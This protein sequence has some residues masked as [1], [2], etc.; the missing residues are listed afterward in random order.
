MFVKGTFKKVGILLTIAVLP[1]LFGYVIITFLLFSAIAF[2]M[3]FFRD[4]NRSTPLNNGLIIAPADGRILK[5]KIDRV[6]TVQYE[7]P[8]MKYILRP[9]E[10]GI[11]VSTFM[12]PFDVH[13]NRAPIS[14][15]IVKTKHYSGK[16]KIAMQN[17]HTE[18]EK[19]LIVIDSEYGKVGVIQI[20]GF[21]ARRI[22]QYVEVG[23]QVQTG[24]RLGMIRFG[25]RVD[26]IIPYENTKLM[27]TEGEKPTAGETVI[28][29]MHK[30]S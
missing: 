20:A 29:R 26:L 30:K 25:S 19:N 14:G 6:K 22:V 8:L 17:V 5:G 11:L 27:V 2:L 18:N 7:D 3:Q 9:E 21:V 15:T 1:F 28:A 4:P 23:D 13:V 10:K 16:F 12:S 24:D